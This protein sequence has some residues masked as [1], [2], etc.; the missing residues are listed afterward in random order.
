[1]ADIERDKF[2]DAAETEEVEE[3]ATDVVESKKKEDKV[4]K[5]DE[6]PGFFKRLGAKLKKF[7][8][9]YKSELKK[10]T[11]YSRK[12]TYVSTLLVLFCMIVSAACIGVL[13]FGFSWAIKG[14]GIFVEFIRGIIG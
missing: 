7:W 2:L 5:A 6:K 12:Q 13:D 4:K 10:I 11:W 3:T 1:M 9:N 8:K 14:L